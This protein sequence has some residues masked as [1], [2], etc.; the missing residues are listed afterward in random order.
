MS[1][2]LLEKTYRVGGKLIQFGAGRDGGREATWTQPIN[3][4]QYVSP[5][6]E[7]NAVPKQWV[8]QAKYHDIGTR[9][10][11]A[12]RRAVESDLDSELD[13]IINT[14]KIPC[15][16][17]VMITNVPL[18]GVHRL[19]SRD[20]IERVVEKWKE[21]VPEIEVWDATDLSSLLDANESVRKA[22]LDDLITGDVLAAVL[23]QVETKVS[24]KREH[25]VSYLRSLLQSEREAK[26]EEAGDD[27]GLPL[28]DIFIDLDVSLR[29]SSGKSS[30]KSRRAPRLHESYRVRDSK[31]VPAST[32]LLHSDAT[33]ILLKGGPGVGKSTLTQ[34][35]T[36]YHAARLIKSDVSKRLEQKLS[37]ND[38]PSCTDA[39]TPLRFPF[40]V[41]LRRYA[42]W[43]AKRDSQP[44][45]LS[46]YL[47]ECMGRAIASDVSAED[48]YEIASTN[49]TLL[50][51]DGLDEVPSAH[52]RE[53]IFT[54]LRKFVGRCDLESARTQII[55]S[56]RPQG[57]RGEV[58][59]FDPV[60]WHVEELSRIN[61]DLYCERWLNARLPSSHDERDDAKSRIH[62]GMLSPAVQQLAKS[63]LQATVML[64][65]AKK[66]L[67]IPHARH[68]LYESYVKVV[69]SREE[70]KETVRQHGRQLHRL[71][72]LVGYRL[73]E[74][75][76]SQRAGGP[77]P[78]ADFHRCVYEI[79]KDYSSHDL[80]EQ[81][82]GIVVDSIT[83]LATDRLCLLAGTG[84]E[85][86]DV[87]FVIQPFREY[88]AAAYLAKHEEASPDRV[89]EALS[90]RSSIW[91]N[92]LQFYCAFK[93]GAEQRAWVLDAD[94]RGVNPEA[95][96]DISR[97]ALAQRTLFHVMPEFME[98]KNHQTRQML[99]I[100]FAKATRWIWFER[101][102]FRNALLAVV[103]G[104]PFAEL[105]DVLFPLS[106]SDSQNLSAELMLLCACAGP[107]DQEKILGILEGLL[108]EG[109]KETRE[110]VLQ[111]A[112][113]FD[114]P[115][116]ISNVSSAEVLEV[117]GR[118]TVQI[119]S[120]GMHD[121]EPRLQALF[122]DELML[123][124]SFGVRWMGRALPDWVADIYLHLGPQ[125]VPS[126]DLTLHFVLHPRASVRPELVGESLARLRA[127]HSPLSTYLASLV[128]LAQEASEESASKAREARAS[129]E[130]MDMFWY[131]APEYQVFV[132]E[133]G[134]DRSLRDP[135]FADSIAGLSLSDGSW[136]T[137]FVAKTAWKRLEQVC[138]VNR[139]RQLRR[140]WP[141]EGDNAALSSQIL[142][143][144]R[145]PPSASISFRVCLDCLSAILDVV[146]EHGSEVIGDLVPALIDLKILEPRGEERMEAVALARHPAFLRLPARW[147]S[148]LLKFLAPFDSVETKQ[149]L[150]LWKCTDHKFSG[151]G[152]FVPSEE[153]LYSLLNTASAD[154][155]TLAACMLTEH[156]P[157]GAVATSL[158]ISV[159]RKLCGLIGS[160]AD[161]ELPFLLRLLRYQKVCCAEELVVW[162]DARTWRNSHRR[163][164]W[165]RED[166]A[167]RI[168]EFGV[169]SVEGEVEAAMTHLGRIVIER[170]RFP[171]EFASAALE[172]LWHLE[173]LSLQPV[174]EVDWLLV[175]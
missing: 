59:G 106:S 13:K 151:L 72:E 1:Q 145:S 128:D 7:N 119:H 147:S 17:Y 125:T 112:V 172:S 169:L 161:R 137:L 150:A 96:A 38:G 85:Q 29:R 3:H 5:T 116:D 79:I 168:S 12:A 160:A 175:D 132:S 73:M 34:F 107:L 91:L 49:P 115:I 14:Y 170:G 78:E 89:Y 139:L 90:K 41:E 105:T 42:A 154:A 171:R 51:L 11:D 48:I 153:R 68:E 57:Y 81:S 174:A 144:L 36:L 9:G 138:G 136:M 122:S 101:E 18:T 66:K 8:F 158:R 166:I 37:C 52:L 25:V 123:A 114:I 54:E 74:Q 28:E 93:S 113:E 159:V 45:H 50:I 152:C 88:F 76:G 69:F 135:R 99:E 44:P 95:W 148:L 21:D 117:I 98:M 55:V 60:E 4:S 103:E 173:E 31:R 94:G 110:V 10:W 43:I 19:G 134:T 64:T 75:L 131:F 87:D 111:T 23:R 121:S 20:R 142:S 157:R 126:E 155:I 149:L 71:H 108:L 162:S 143:D 86:K 146:E 165:W 118:T 120:P 164:W 22:Y 24:L 70:G 39:S 84:D 140:C 109:T 63:L 83:R 6:T 47:S 26:A 30:A 124:L 141:T 80:G 129:I 61:F 100:V 67:A 133:L 32:A 156:G 40:R 15:H 62:S 97:M 163:G 82:I 2:A 27:S 77:L 16:K 35:L 53:I 92:V 56:T 46:H 102:G 65:I 33:Y 58:D 104:D 130:G 167:H 127:I